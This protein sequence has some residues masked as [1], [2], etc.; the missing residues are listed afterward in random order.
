MTDRRLTLDVLVDPD[1]ANV[2]AAALS[3]LASF[4]ASVEPAL[5]RGD[6]TVT[7]RL[8][9]DQRIAEIHG[10]FFDDST[11]TDVISFPSGEDLAAF[12]GHLGDIVVSVAT[13]TDNAADQ[14]HSANR[15]IA[16]LLLHGLLHLCG[17]DDAGEEERAAMLA[18]QSDILAAFEAVAGEP[19]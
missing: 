1:V 18:R 6:W 8:T 7:L 17:F 12:G 9:D 16:F 14:G 10:R 2:P 15:E 11:P 5:P 19:W 3:E 4:A 13:A